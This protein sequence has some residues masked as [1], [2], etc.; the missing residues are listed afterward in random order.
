MSEL[1]WQNALF[2]DRILDRV[3]CTLCPHRCALHD[4]DMGRCFVRRR[5]GERLE[6]AAFSTVVRHLHP[7]ERK[8]FYHFLPGS[9]VL[10]LAPPGCTF[11]CT[12][13]QNFRISQVGRDERATVLSEIIDPETTVEAA[14]AVGAH[15]ALS[16]SEPTLAAELTLALARPAREKGVSIV[17]KSNGFITPEALTELAPAISAINLDLKSC[18]SRAH[19]RLTG[20]FVEPVLKALTLWVQSGTWVEISTPLIPGLNDD[21]AA[22][23]AMAEFVAGLG[24][25]IPWH[26]LRFHPDYRY[27]SAPPT[28]P[29]RLARA[30][31]VAHA[32]GLKYVY[33]ERALGEPGRTTRCSSCGER[34]ISR[35]LEGGAQLHFSDGIC[36]QCSTPLAGVWKGISP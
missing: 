3:R 18:N 14:R 35:G 30:L 34:L 1:Q 7:I 10:T 25:D 36:P 13:C 8:P 9:Q 11:A 27:R 33:V 23:A 26:L 16:Y 19:H 24:T 22:V 12:Y 32:V 20:A 2:Y 28:S 6:T 21:D 4:G 17:W 5:R 15:L 31:Q 29:E